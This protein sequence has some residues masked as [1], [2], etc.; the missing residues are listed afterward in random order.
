MLSTDSLSRN[1][2]TKCSLCCKYT[3]FDMGGGGPFSLYLCKWLFQAK[4]EAQSHFVA[5]SSCV[6]IMMKGAK[7]II[8]VKG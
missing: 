6:N 1:A 5:S 4:L 7:Q 2:N 8:E 3:H